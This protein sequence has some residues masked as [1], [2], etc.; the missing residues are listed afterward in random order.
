MNEKLNEIYKNSLYTISLGGGITL[1]PGK[2]PEGDVMLLFSQPVAIITAWNPSRESDEA[3]ILT[4]I[5]NHQREEAFREELIMEG[6]EFFPA[7]GQL[8]DHSED[9]EAIFRISQE[10]AMRFAI[11]YGQKAFVYFDSKVTSLVYTDFTGLS[12]TI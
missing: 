11:K 6:F 5:E 12:N 7:K 3:V 10:D 4:D 1:V 9:S 2:E 8:H